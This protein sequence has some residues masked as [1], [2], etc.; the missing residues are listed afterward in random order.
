MP[1]ATQNFPIILIK[2]ESKLET[3]YQIQYTYV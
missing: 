2:F 1:Q 3:K